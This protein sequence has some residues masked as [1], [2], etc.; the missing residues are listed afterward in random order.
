[1]ESAGHEAVKHYGEKALDN[2]ADLILVSVGALA[3]ESLL[4][5]I[6][7]KHGKQVVKLWFLQPQLEV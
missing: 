7:R 6:R 5:T 1:M 3:D 2:R 4:L